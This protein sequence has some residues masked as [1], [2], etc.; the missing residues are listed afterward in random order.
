MAS[1]RLVS[2]EIGSSIIRVCE[3][4][5]K[6]KSAKVF[7]NFVVETPKGT[8]ADGEIVDQESLA[9]YLKDQLSDHGISSKQ[10]LFVLTSTKIANREVSIP[11]VKENRIRSLIETN[12]NDYFP[13][14]L[15]DYELA[16]ITLGN[17]PKAKDA[18]SPRIR[19]MVLAAPK[20]LLN[21]YRD[22]AKACGLTVAGIDYSGNSL[23]QVTKQECADDTVM[24]L[25]IDG[26]YSMITIISNGSIVLQ[27]TVAYGLAGM[28][29]T[30]NNPNFLSVLGEL[31][32]NNFFQVQI[33]QN[34]ALDDEDGDLGNF[35]IG[36]GRSAVNSDLMG[37]ADALING[38]SRVI[39]FYNSRNSSEPISHILLT[40]LGSTVKGLGGYIEHSLAIP[41][42]PLVE[43]A[44]HALDKEFDKD[45]MGKYITCFGGV[46]SPIKFAPLGE[47]EKGKKG[48]KEKR[49]G[50]DFGIKQ[51]LAILALCIIIAIGLCA[52]TLIPYSLA[53]RENKK[54]RTEAE[55][56]ASIVPI[57]QEYVQSKNADY[58][59]QAALEA[60]NIP[61]ENLADLIE[62]MEDKF[63]STMYA[64]A[65][66]ADRGGISM[67]VTTE[68]KMDAADLLVQMRE[69]ES[70]TNVHVSAIT[71]SNTEETYGEVKFSVTADYVLGER[72]EVNYDPT[73]TLDSLEDDV[74][75]L[76]NREEEE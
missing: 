76:T 65:L 20:T 38:I 41:V 66:T 53:K 18:A 5:Q 9:Y 10:V 11:F 29:S 35:S 25:K 56:L 16:Y 47:G 13:V 3:M 19:L 8:V 59:I 14:D 23:F 2:I 15:A 55:N 51:A 63:P 33:R 64:S 46:I 28:A 72:E 37:E 1:K 27:R 45:E 44:G 12:A 42:E 73:D 60:T 30:F 69:F 24:V 50:A 7:K 70:I 22:L 52:Y 71:D 6:A 74:A 75:G 36:G 32:R 31:S 4:E 62:E 58:Y 39:N 67:Q 49:P 17:D 54:L 68:E 43:A 57:Y 48:G 34:A 61:V 21:G 40:G 26:G